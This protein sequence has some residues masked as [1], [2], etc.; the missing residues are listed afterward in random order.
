MS[1]KNDNQL[2]GS[3]GLGMT[4]LVA[5]I[6]ACKL[7]NAT[8]DRHEV[9]RRLMA[10]AAR[11]AG[12]DRATLYLLDEPGS[13][14]Y[15]IVMTGSGDDAAL[16]EIRLPLNEGLSGHVART[17]ETVSVADAYAD[18]RFS[19]RI[20]EETGYRTQEVLAVPLCN[21][22][23]RIIGVVQV[24]NKLQGAFAQDDE[25]YLLALAEHAAL[26]LENVRQHATLVT[27]Y[28]RLSFLYRISS[29]IT[30]VGVPGVDAGA[31][32]PAGKARLR[33]VLL[34]VMEGVNEILDTESSAILLWD[35]RRRRL[36]FVTVVGPGERELMEVDV[37]L[38]GSIAGWIIQNEQ[39]VIV[40]EVQA[41]A[42]H[43]RGAD[44][45]TGLVTHTL[46]GAPVKMDDK[47]IGVLE[48]VNKHN[49]A[50][51]NQA[52]LQL[53]QAV[54]DHTALA[55]ENARRYESLL[56]VGEH[57]ERRATTGLLD[58]LG[59]FRG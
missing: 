6:D 19:P 37:P 31:E 25:R 11:G 3:G 28:R 26:A 22:Q 21:P 2:S 52:D 49:D 57:Q 48:A 16:R 47:V 8:L 46:V 58:S 54:A 34:T 36:A 55:I 42:R 41:D 29:L 20:D 5:L 51:F 14:L 32:M 33:D 1:V 24:L 35:Q 27:E 39:A 45:R 13:Q 43:Y 30:G 4:R 15:S 50:S 17:G 18:P 59:L 40:N 56:R 44:A 12:A 53:L 23:G 9:L 38:E 10:L 7:L